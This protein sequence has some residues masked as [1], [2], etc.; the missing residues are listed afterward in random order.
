MKLKYI[1]NILQH[2]SLGEKRI[3]TLAFSPD[4]QRL[5]AVNDSNKLLMYEISNSEFILKDQTK[6][7]PKNK[8]KPAFQ[9]KKIAFSPDSRRIAC[10]QMDGI[11]YVY[12]FYLI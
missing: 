1:S 2:K 11:L 12:Q 4:G 8:E 6:L 3:H 9:V 5:A 7:K 10:A